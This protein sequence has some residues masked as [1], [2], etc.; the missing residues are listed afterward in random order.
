M[1]VKAVKVASIDTD[2]FTKT[3]EYEVLHQSHVGVNHNKFYC[4]EIQHNPKK[5][6]YRLFSHYGRLG[7]TNV[8]D[9][10]GP[11]HTEEEAKKE[12]D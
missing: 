6:K 9:V 5:K 12:F 1:G 7:K 2:G 8:Y 3:I 10:R 11:I 4:L